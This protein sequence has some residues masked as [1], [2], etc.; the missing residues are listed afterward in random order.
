MINKN[1]SK[2]TFMSIPI[3]IMTLMKK[4]LT[5]V[6]F[7]VVLASQLWMGHALGPGKIQGK[8]RTG[9]PVA[10]GTCGNCHIG[11]AFD[12]KTTLTLTDANNN[13]VT[14]YKSGQT[15]SLKIGV[16]GAGLNGGSAATLFGFQGVALNNTNT[17]A[18][19][20]TIP[21]TVQTIKVGGRDL[22]EHKTPKGSGTWDVMWT[23]PAKNTGMVKFYFCGN[24]C[25]G[26]NGSSGDKAAPAILTL[27]ESTATNENIAQ[28]FSIQSLVTGNSRLI[29]GLNVE[30]SAEYTFQIMDLNGVIQT[31]IESW[32]NSGSSSNELDLGKLPQG[33]YI[34]TISNGF[35][36]LTRKFFK[37]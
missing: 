15:Y 26:A 13:Q 19:T 11:G 22:I 28:S 36:S 24:A 12:A 20:F 6:L 1:V 32:L 14:K 35:E 31:N 4:R 18:G 7:F 33:I 9:S 25:N 27:E 23:A 21:S 2:C 29:A 3:K 16:T 10:D 8:E 5:Y 34:L 37:Q 17:N 30:K